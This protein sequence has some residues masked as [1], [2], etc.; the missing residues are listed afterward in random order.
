MQAI[1]DSI[2]VKLSSTRIDLNESLNHCYSDDCGAINTFIGT[3][4]NATKGEAVKNLFFEAYEPMA[5]KELVKLAL[6]AQ[7]QWSIKKISIV[8]RLGEVPIGE[9]AVVIA[10]ASAH[11]KESFLA[12]EFLIDQLKVTVPIWKKERL[13]SGEVWV[14]AHP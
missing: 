2:L 14:S 3:V 5:H 4:R 7:E 9:E 10:V 13:E 8:H 12:C 1:S 11:R 6:K